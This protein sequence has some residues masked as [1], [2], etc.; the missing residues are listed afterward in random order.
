M[1]DPYGRTQVPKLE[2]I[3]PAF[4]PLRPFRF[5]LVGYLQL[6]FALFY[7][8][9]WVADTLDEGPLALILTLILWA[10]VFGLVFIPA[11][12]IGY[13]ALVPAI[14]QF[15]FHAYWFVA[16]R[17]WDDTE[18]EKWKSWTYFK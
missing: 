17:L 4:S 12:W 8:W 1:S 15:L 10:A 3:K 18:R 11:I 16:L 9:A 6:V 13:W 2:P 5:A 7:A 14:G